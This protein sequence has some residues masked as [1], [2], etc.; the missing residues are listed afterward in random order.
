MPVYR[1][2][3]SRIHVILNAVHAMTHNNNINQFQDIFKIF[4]R[5]RGAETDVQ[6]DEHFPTLFGSAENAFC[7]FYIFHERVKIIQMMYK[8]SKLRLVHFDKKKLNKI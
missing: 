6:T 5:V 4:T 2:T 1:Q 8:T 3:S 7:K